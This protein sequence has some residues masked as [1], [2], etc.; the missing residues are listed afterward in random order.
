MYKIAKIYT[1]FSS[2]KKYS[3]VHSKLRN[4]LI[5]ERIKN[6]VNDIAII[7]DWIISFEESFFDEFKNY[8]KFSG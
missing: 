1:F 3:F 6:V 4:K 7:K 8:E 2:A 5:N